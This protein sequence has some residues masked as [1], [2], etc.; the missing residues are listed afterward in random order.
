M[1]SVQLLT[2][3]LIAFSMLF[4]AFTIVPNI[5]DA[6]R[7]REIVAVDSGNSFNMRLS[8]GGASHLG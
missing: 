3:F 5:A 4:S 1:K 7:E 8:E 6:E 2:V